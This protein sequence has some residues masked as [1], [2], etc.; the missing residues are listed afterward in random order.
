MNKFFLFSNFIFNH[1]FKKWLLIKKKNKNF[2]NIKLS[3]KRRK[4]KWKK[5][6]YKV[7]F[8]FKNYFR[9]CFTKSN[10]YFLKSIKNK[11]NWFVFNFYWYN[12]FFLINF[13]SINFFNRKKFFLSKKSRLRFCKTNFS[14]IF[15]R[16]T[17]Y[18]F[19]LS[20]MNNTFI[21]TYI[22]IFFKFFL[23]LLDYNINMSKNKL[24][25][26]LKKKKLIFKLLFYFFSLY[27]DK[28]KYFFYFINFNFFKFFFF[29]IKFFFF[30]LI[31]LNRFYFIFEVIFFKFRYKKDLK[32]KTFLNSFL[33]NNFFF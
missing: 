26:N 21:N 5:K 18:N 6:R 3:K 22:Y 16:E 11:I 13:F 10:S 9:N 14:Y 28:L 19:S 12:L 29:I 20:K 7:Y 4:Y 23:F 32:I 25:L 31:Y 1:R 27:L 17:N 30:Q 8:F 33:K 2:K 24:K 15:R